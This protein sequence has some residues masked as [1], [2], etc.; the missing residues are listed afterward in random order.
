MRKIAQAQAR[1]A[2]RRAGALGRASTTSTT[3]HS[4][5]RRGLLTTACNA[6]AVASCAS[7][8]NTTS[9]SS[10]TNFAQLRPRLQQRR[11][12]GTKFAL[13]DALADTLNDPAAFAETG[14]TPLAVYNALVKKGVVEED[15]MQ[16]R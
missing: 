3:A 5:Q 15:G 1:T 11:S 9:A 2:A 7:R 6:H 12:F 13:D 8:F 16:L 10:T 4:A 14:L